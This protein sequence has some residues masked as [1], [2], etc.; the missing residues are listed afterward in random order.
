[1]SNTRRGA[2]WLKTIIFI[3]LFLCAGILHA[4]SEKRIAAVSSRGGSFFLMRGGGIRQSYNPSSLGDGVTLNNSDMIQTPSGVFV[5]ARVVP[6]TVS[7]HIAENSSLLFEN[8]GGSS[9]TQVIALVYGRIRID[10]E[11]AGETVIVKAGTSI[12]EIQKGSV[13]IDYIATGEDGRRSQPVLY[14]SAIS[15]SAVLV[16][17]TQSPALGRIKVNQNETMVFYA[18]ENKVEKTAINKG[19]L[20]YW[21]V[22]S[23]AAPPDNVNV[24]D[25]SGVLALP[26]SPAAESAERVAS[27]KTGGIITGL[28][29]TL[30]G[31]AVQNAIHYAYDHIDKETADLSYYAGFLPIGLGTFILV[32]SF[33]YPAY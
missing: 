23:A 2:L 15:G 33:L 18:P 29:L 11:D 6:G 9:R 8:I 25:S 24:F 17:S 13:N 12:T 14:V 19:V 4:Q 28:V 3:E 5:E 30:V 7:I 32:A 31:V 10:Q 27:L 20:K 26:A 22:G 21:S 16:P 1:M